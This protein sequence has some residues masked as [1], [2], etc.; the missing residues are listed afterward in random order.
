[1]EETPRFFN[2]LYACVPYLEKRWWDIG[3]QL[4]FTAEELNEINSPLIPCCKK[5]LYLWKQRNKDVTAS[6]LISVIKSCGEDL[7]ASQLQG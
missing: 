1:M 7:Y 2:R 5:M 3:V 4:Q 6:N